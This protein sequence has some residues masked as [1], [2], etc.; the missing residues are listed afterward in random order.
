[1]I[2]QYFEG[3]AMVIAAEH[4]EDLVMPCHQY[5]FLDEGKITAHYTRTQ[6]PRLP[7][8]VTIWGGDISSFQREKMEILVRK[9]QY[10][11]FLYREI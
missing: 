11:R 6:L 3:T 7:K 1:M 5:L 9:K 4:F 2:G 8:V 10:I